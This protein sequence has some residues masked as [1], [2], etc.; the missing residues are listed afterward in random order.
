MIE[1]QKR[2]QMEQMK[3]VA[4]AADAKLAEEK[5]KQLEEE[6]KEEVKGDAD[7]VKI[8]QI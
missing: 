1:A 8:T 4:Q 3:A 7:Q 6:K 5:R 2:A